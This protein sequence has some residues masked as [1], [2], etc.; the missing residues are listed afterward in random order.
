VNHAFGCDNRQP[1]LQFNDLQTD[2]AR[3][4]QKGFLFLY[5]G[6]V[7]L[8]NTKAHSNRAFDSPQRGFEYLALASLLLRLLETARRN[9]GSQ[10]LPPK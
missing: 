5:K 8:R 9:A 4:E 3:D 7:S 2:A 10:D 6:I 1:L